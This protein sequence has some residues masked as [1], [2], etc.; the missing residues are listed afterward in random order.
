M[1]LILITLL[2]ALTI[3][4]HGQETKPAPI[5]WESGMTKVLIIAGGSSH[6]FKKWFEDY[7]SAFLKTAGFTV[8]VTEDA[9]V[10]VAEL[11]NVDVAIISSNKTGLDTPEYRAALFDFAARG[12]GIIMLHPG[13]WYGFNKWPEINAKIIGGGA[14]SHDPLGPFTVNVLQKDHLM[15]KDVPASFAVFDELYHV[16]PEP[17]KNTTSIDVLAETTPSKKFNKTHPS[18]W[19]T[20]ND[21]ARI[22]G[23]ALGHDGRVHELDFFKKILINAVNWTSKK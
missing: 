22:V 14:K 5:K 18:V 2:Y 4:V 17:S 7:D 16:N 12:K 13:T 19:I 6:D 8:N 10:A 9:A 23:I 20:K 21:K 11:K 3:S 15:M 1:K